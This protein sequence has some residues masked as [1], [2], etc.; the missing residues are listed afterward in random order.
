VAARPPRRS[1]RKSPTPTPKIPPRE[2]WFDA[3]DEPPPAVP[4]RSLDAPGAAR[5]RPG[6]GGGAS[7]PAC[8]PARRSCS[9]TG[10][11]SS[12]GTWV[13]RATALRAESRCGDAAPLEHGSWCDLKGVVAYPTLVATGRGEHPGRR[14]SRSATAGRSSSR[15]LEGDRVFLVV[16]GGPGGRRSTTVVEF[17]QPLRFPRRGG[18]SDHRPG[19]STRGSRRSARRCGSASR[20]P[21]GAP[22]R[23]FDTT[24]EPLGNWFV[25][26]ALVVVL[27]IAV[28]SVFS[29]IGAGAR[30]AGEG[31]RT[32]RAH[33]GERRSR[34]PW[35]RR[36]SFRVQLY[37][38]GAR[39]PVGGRLGSRRFPLRCI[40]SSARAFPV[41][42]SGASSPGG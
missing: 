41:A 35:P 34:R 36:P 28:R 15:Q 13:A 4:R 31:R 5:R 14:R 26:L 12:A 37:G 7:W 24:D 19:S 9:S 3:G 39:P 22:M 6:D 33:R 40:G 2:A 1:R 30:G 20:I 29:A 32:R 27:F 8:R 23:L 21:A 16:A 18:R 38:R 11:R 25:G 42:A 17:R 10:A